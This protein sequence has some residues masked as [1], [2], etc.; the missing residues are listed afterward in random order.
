MSV[1]DPVAPIV[2]HGH[3]GWFVSFFFPSITEA[4]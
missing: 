4:V 3:W 1:E 2:V